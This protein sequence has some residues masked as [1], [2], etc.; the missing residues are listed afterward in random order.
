MT[1]GSRIRAA[2]EAKSLTQPQLAAKVGNIKSSVVSMWEND[3]SRPDLDRL[4]RLCKALDVSS[5]E[6]LGLRIDVS[7][8]TSEELERN[9][10]IRALD[11][12]GLEMV[13]FVIEKEYA[14][15][16]E[17][18]K[19]KARILKIDWYDMPV[20]AGTGMFLDSAPTESIL[21]YES[22]IAEE[23]DFV[24]SVAGDSM[25]P[26]FRDGD[27][28]F[29]RKQDSINE[30][31]IGIFVLNG[32]AYIKQLGRKCLIS[33]NPA[34]KP[35]QLHADDSVYCFGKVIGVADEYEG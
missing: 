35:I 15:I 33:L 21:V 23:A 29:V 3:K 31:E 22:G 19:E 13:D 18:A 20:S 5:D 34:Y 9:K 17:K 11:E 7:K 8:P 28:V 2:R 10:K 32:D 4:S 16:S 26:S 14:R 12:H 27:K 1:I 25:E 24:L 6:L 30:G